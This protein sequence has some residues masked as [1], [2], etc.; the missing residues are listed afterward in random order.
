MAQKTRSLAQLA[1]DERRTGWPEKAIAEM[2]SKGFMV[3]I[4]PDES[5]RWE[6]L[7]ADSGQTLSG[8]LMR[9]WRGSDG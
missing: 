7:A 5:A 9:P 6:A 3:H 1:A 8:V 2:R 4:T